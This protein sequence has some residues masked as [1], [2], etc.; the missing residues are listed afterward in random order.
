MEHRFPL[1]ILRHSLR[2]GSGGEGQWRGGLGIVRVYELLDDT[3]INLWFERS[4]TPSWGIAGGKAG[5]A[6]DVWV[7][8]PGHEPQQILKCEAVPVPAG[9]RI[10]VFTGGGGGWGDPDS[11][12][13]NARRED[14]RL[15]LVARSTGRPDGPV[16]STRRHR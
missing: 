8:V 3:R 1:R 9:T 16:E 11:R 6:P 2:E 13:E 5:A 12:S 15:G 7:N 14:E 10:D 4:K